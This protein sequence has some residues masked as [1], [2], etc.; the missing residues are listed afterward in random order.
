MTI[1][2]LEANEYEHATP[3]ICADC[4]PEHAAD[5]CAIC[6]GQSGEEVPAPMDG[7]RTNES[8]NGA[9]SSCRADVACNDFPSVLRRKLE[10][11]GLKRCGHRFCVACLRKHTA[12]QQGLGSAV[13][14]PVC[15]RPL[16]MCDVLGASETPLKA[17]MEPD[18][19][20]AEVAPPLPIPR[21][22]TQADQRRRERDERKAQLAFEATARKMHMKM[23]PH[24]N[25]PIIKDGGCNNM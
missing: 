22:V 12:Q 25:A 10:L 11:Q 1:A 17:C 24:C 14:C 23:C 21:V 16:H 2:Q 3:P 9:E 7:A 15:R 6:L 4:E 20:S 5:C 13:W 19:G 18:D 8:G